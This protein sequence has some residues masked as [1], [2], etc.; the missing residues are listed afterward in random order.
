MENYR[1]NTVKVIQLRVCTVLK[2]WLD[3]Q[4]QDFDHEL[5]QQVVNFVDNLPMEYEVVAHGLRQAILKRVFYFQRKPI[6]IFYLD[7]WVEKRTKI[8]DWKTS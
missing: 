6:L 5:T 4:W 3:V 1:K 8:D 2:A 7:C